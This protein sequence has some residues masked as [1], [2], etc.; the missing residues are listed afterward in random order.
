MS[1]EE[2]RACGN[3]GYAVAVLLMCDCGMLL[4]KTCQHI[5]QCAQMPQRQSITGSVNVTATLTVDKA[6][7]NAPT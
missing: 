1:T 7:G 2:T 3:C 6:G 4:C 5:H